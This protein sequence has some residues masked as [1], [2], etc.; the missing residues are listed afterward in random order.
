[1]FFV[2]FVCGIYAEFVRVRMA[3]LYP[4][5]FTMGSQALSK[6]GDIRNQVECVEN[7]HC[8]QIQSVFCHRTNSRGDDPLYGRWKCWERLSSPSNYTYSFKVK[9]ESWDEMKDGFVVEG[10]C[11]VFIT[12]DRKPTPT[13][14]MITTVYILT[15]IMMAAV[16]AILTPKSKRFDD[17]WVDGD[18]DVDDCDGD[19]GD[20][21]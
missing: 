14:Q 15:F 11:H 1:M 12:S 19:D 9:C 20:A 16:F 17:D 7:S 8:S 10:S 2:M 18:C 6:R 4:M 13:E 21:D 5:E 3:E